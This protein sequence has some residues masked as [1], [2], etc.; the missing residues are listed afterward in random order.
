MARF[1]FDDLAPPDDAV[2]RFD[3]E[4]LIP[5]DCGSAFVMRGL[6]VKRKADE[7]DREKT[8]AAEAVVASFAIAGA[9]ARKVQADAEQAEAEAEDAWATFLTGELI[10][11]VEEALQERDATVKLARES[12]D[13]GYDFSPSDL[14]MILHLVVTGGSGIATPEDQV[15][16]T[17]TGKDAKQ[18]AKEEKEARDAAVAEGKDPTTPSKRRGTG[19]SGTRSPA[20]SPT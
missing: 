9:E 20:S 7:L 2:K 12:G 11:Y 18:R 19:R 14:L 5:A 8:E 13:G 15:A 6:R 4:F 1:D 3:R 16:E 17:L 10:P